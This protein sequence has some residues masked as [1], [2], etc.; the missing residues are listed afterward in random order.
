[1]TRKIGSCPIS[2]LPLYEIS[3]EQALLCPA[4]VRGYSFLGK[5]WAFFLV[6]EVKEI[7]WHADAFDSLELDPRMK[8][9]IL[10]MV[11]THRHNDNFE[12]SQI[13]K[14]MT[15]DLSEYV[16]DIIPGKGK[17]L[18]FLLYGRPGLGKTLTA[19]K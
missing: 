7:D 16:Q 18:V 5:I 14:T 9:A 15:R 12:V 13:L 11:S 3:D 19:G 4:R 2:T 10:A 1:M 6:D 17:G 8:S